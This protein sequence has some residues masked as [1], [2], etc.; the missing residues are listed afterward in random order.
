[1]TEKLSTHYKELNAKTIANN[2]HFVTLLMAREK[3]VEKPIITTKGNAE[4]I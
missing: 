2:P 4:K 1:M 3:G